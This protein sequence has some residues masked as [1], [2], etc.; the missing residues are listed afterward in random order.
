MAQHNGKVV[1]RRF[2][3][4]VRIV[5]LGELNDAR[6][7]GNVDYRTCPGGGVRGVEER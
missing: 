7:A 2:R 4:V 3:R 5:E 1:S 6:D